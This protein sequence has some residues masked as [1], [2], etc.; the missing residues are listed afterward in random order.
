MSIQLINEDDHALYVDARKKFLFRPAATTVVSGLDGRS[1]DDFERDLRKRLSDLGSDEV[2][3]G[4]GVVR[5]AGDLAGNK[6][7]ASALGWLPAD[8]ERV[9]DVSEDVRILA[10]DY[11]A[12]DIRFKEWRE[13]V[14]ESSEHRFKDTPVPGPPSTLMLCRHMLRNGGSPDGWLD[15]WH[16][17][18]RVDRTDR[19]SHEL[20]AL[21]KTLKTA[22]TYEQVN[23]GGLASLEVV[24]RRIQAIIDAYTNVPHSKPNWGAADLYEGGV[25]VD[26]GICDELTNYA[27]RRARERQDLQSMRSRVQG[28]GKGKGLDGDPGELDIAGPNFQTARAHPS[29]KEKQTA[30][31]GAPQKE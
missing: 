5:G 8:D 26:E 19:V 28:K 6:Q 23:L 1:N 10:V 4:A 31:V 25:A 11:D 21:V 30:G 18:K 12:H 13:A 22:G 14:A 2:V 7:L 20:C 17:A 29:K 9:A 16:D 15:R 3:T 24:A 27:S